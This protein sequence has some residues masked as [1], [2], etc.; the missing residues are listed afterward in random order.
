MKQKKRYCLPPCEDYDYY[1]LECWLTEMVRQGWV[2]E[3]IDYANSLWCFR[4]GEAETYTVL[5][6]RQVR[7]E[8]GWELVTK[9]D[10]IR[11][12]RKTDP[13]AED[14]ARE[15]DRMDGAVKASKGVNLIGNGI[16]LGLLAAGWILFGSVLAMY[17]MQ[18]LSL[19]WGVT[20]MMAILCLTVCIGM[21]LGCWLRWRKRMEQAMET[22]NY[23]VQ[24]PWISRWA[25]ILPLAAAGV[26]GFC[27]TTSAAA[28]AVIVI[29]L[30]LMALPQIGSL[31]GPT[32][33]RKKRMGTIAITALTAVAMVL[34][35]LLCTLGGWMQVNDLE[36]Q[37]ITLPV[38]AVDLSFG[39]AQA[40]VNGTHTYHVTEA[41]GSITGFS[42]TGVELDGEGERVSDCEVFLC[43]IPLFWDLCREQALERFEEQYDTVTLQTREDLDGYAVVSDESGDCILIFD[44]DEIIQLRF[45]WNLSENQLN[46]ALGMI[47]VDMD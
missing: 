30:L 34:G 26:F 38:T 12:Y 1:G 15:P 17:P 23:A 10:L 41:D 9:Y 14:L 29:F 20:G 19:S 5:V 33:C 44:N 36:G 4:E 32:I 35:F 46:R 28:R 37:V 7:S 16:L 24:V 6:E 42:Y 13:A 3:D 39:E 31:L 21:E 8:S 11:V 18:M 27:S 43:R 22:G 2:L 25:R 40:P 47:G 45:T